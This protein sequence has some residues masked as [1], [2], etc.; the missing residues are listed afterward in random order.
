MSV[1]QKN[2]Y[3]TLTYGLL[4]LVPFVRVFGSFLQEPLA[5]G[6]LG[7]DVCKLG[8]MILSIPGGLMPG[9]SPQVQEESASTEFE[10]PEDF[11]DVATPACCQQKPTQDVASLFTLEGGVTGMSELPGLHFR[12]HDS[13]LEQWTSTFRIS[14]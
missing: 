10:V 4:L 12:H 11:L 8:L 3:L 13:V 7:L 6:D 2:C 14:V 1:A 5:G 9:G